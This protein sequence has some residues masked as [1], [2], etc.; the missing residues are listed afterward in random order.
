MHSLRKPDALFI[1]LIM[2]M[3]GFGIYCTPGFFKN[4]FF[5]E[6][7]NKA[8]NGDV[9]EQLRL[10]QLYD[11]G[12]FTE[13]DKEQSLGWYKKAALNGSNVAKNILC[14]KYNIGCPDSISISYT[15]HKEN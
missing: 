11:I 14:D 9:R 7:Y 2:C 10:A 3:I 8:I 4:V 5:T 6:V 12:K 13:P 1:I 15:E